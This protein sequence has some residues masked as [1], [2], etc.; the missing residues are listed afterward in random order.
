MFW[1]GYF[2]RRPLE[3]GRLCSENSEESVSQSVTLQPLPR[4]LKFISGTLWQTQSYIPFGNTL[5]LTTYLQGFTR[6]EEAVKMQKR[7]TTTP[8]PSSQTTHPSYL[9]TY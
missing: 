2:L 9:P 6:M 8:Y 5:T 4:T 1:G 7:K 3:G